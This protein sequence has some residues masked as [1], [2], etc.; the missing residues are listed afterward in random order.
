MGVK[1]RRGGE[2]VREKQ[3]KV[4]GKGRRS[5][6]AGI[7]GGSSQAKGFGEGKEKIMRRRG[8]A[9]QRGGL[10]RSGQKLNVSHFRGRAENFCIGKGATAWRSVP[11]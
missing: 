7:G 4:K 3:S 9:K 1:G 6:G 8:G 2:V 5:N 11:K 10:W